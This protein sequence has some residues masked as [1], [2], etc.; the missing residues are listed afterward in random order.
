M[1]GCSGLCDAFKI[2]FIKSNSPCVL[3]SVCVDE[4]TGEEV[5]LA[6]L[7]ECGCVCLSVCC[8]CMFLCVRA[9]GVLCA[10]LKKGF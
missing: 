9:C 4:G 5:V 1:S 6:C 7:W 3:V 2:N 10:Y 8:M